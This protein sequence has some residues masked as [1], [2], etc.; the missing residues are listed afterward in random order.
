MKEIPSKV[1]KAI[2]KVGPS[3][4]SL[5]SRMAKIPEST[6]R[7]NVNRL[8]RMGILIQPAIGYERLGLER[9]WALFEFGDKYEGKEKQFF[10]AMSQDAYLIYFTRLLPQGKYAAV[11]TIPTGV[12]EEHSQF[13]SGLIDDG[14]LK[15]CQMR[16]LLWIRHPEM[17]TEYYDFSA[18]T[19]DIDWEAIG[20]VIPSGTEPKPEELAQQR[21]D[22]IDLLI[23]KE[24][25]SDSIA[26]LTK[27][28]RKLEINSKTAYYH[29]RNHILARKLL[30]NYVLRW[31][32]FGK[33]KYVT[34]PIKFWYNELTGSE[35]MQVQKL[36]NSIPLVWSDAIS[37]DRSIYVAELAVPS[38]QLPDLLSFVWNGTHQFAS[39][40]NFGFSDPS[41][42]VSYSIPY[43]MFDDGWSFNAK[44][45]L[46]GMKQMSVANKKI[47]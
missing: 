15:S 10:Q 5:I 46:S 19:W 42:D 36:F 22:K 32:G 6:V 47:G 17:K 18:K 16:D 39:K 31:R 43:H 28:A 3:N 7:Y 40:L 27:I 8:S 44:E 4:Y 2:A 20:R 23:L 29:Y 24:V 21:I 30:K 12:K 41:F 1:A 34:V 11:L 25:Q 38:E 35:L 26:S 9:C 13:I 45:A 33:R 37:K 14:I